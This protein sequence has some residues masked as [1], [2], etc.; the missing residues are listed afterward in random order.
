[1]KKVMAMMLSV[2]CCFAAMGESEMFT[3]DTRDGTRV[4]DRAE[5]IHWS[6][7][8]SGDSNAMVVVTLNN[9]SL[10]NYETGEGE[11]VWD[12]LE[13]GTYTFKH[14]TFQ[15]GIR[16]GV[17]L[18]ATFEI[19]EETRTGVPYQWLEDWWLV[20]PGVSREVY[21]TAALMDVDG[22]GFVAWQEYVAGTDPNDPNSVFSTGIE[23]VDGGVVISWTQ[24]TDG[25]DTV[26]RAYTV[27]QLIDGVWKDVQVTQDA[28]EMEIAKPDTSEAGVWLYRVKVNLL[29]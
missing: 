5:T 10:V 7:L 4:T 18:T 27:Q 20:K 17:P 12:E 16:V 21:E 28:S 14:M 23:I 9:K 25:E 19:V 1:M 29:E 8:W 24:P 6:A 3:L 26:E 2:A 22:D 15:D 13:P 11:I